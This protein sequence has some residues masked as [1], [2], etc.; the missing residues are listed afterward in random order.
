MYNLAL[1]N[2]CFYNYKCS[3]YYMKLNHYLIIQRDKLERVL[4]FL[5]VIQAAYV[6]SAMQIRLDEMLV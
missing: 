3:L 1:K 6:S 4:N 2:N 5:S